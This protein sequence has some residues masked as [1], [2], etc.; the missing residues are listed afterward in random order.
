MCGI[1]GQLNFRGN[2]K[3]ESVNCMINAVR[4]RGPDDSGVMASGNH[5]VV[6]GHRRLSILDLSSAGHQPMRSKDGKTLLVFN[7]EIYNYKELKLR[8]FNEED[9]FISTGDSELLLRLWEKLGQ[10]CVPLLRGM[11]AFAIW[12]ERKEAL[13]LVRDPCGI[14]PLYYKRHEFL[15]SSGYLFCSELKGLKAFLGNLELEYEA[16]GLFLKW[17]SIPAPS[18]IYK[19]VTALEAGT[20]LRISR[21]REDV[22][23]YWS[24]GEILC[25]AA[26]DPFY[27]AN[28]EDAV[29]YVRDLL[30][31]SVGLHLVSDVPVGA[32]L[33]GGVDSSA[34]VSLMHALGQ[35]QIGTFCIGFESAHF[36]ESQYAQK[37][38][39]L[40]ETDHTCWVITQS[41]FLEVQERFFDSMEQP[42]I[43]GLNTFLV[44]DLAFRQGYKVVTSGIGGDEIFAG[45][46]RD[47]RKLP[48]I[49]KLVQAIGPLLRSAGGAALTAGSSMGLLSPQ[50]QRVQAFLAGA[51]TLARA[52]DMGRGLFTGPEITAI[53]A[54]KELGKIIAETNGDRFLPDLKEILN[55]RDAVSCFLLER[56][57]GPQLLRDSDAFSMSFSLEL[58]TPLVDSVL[59]EKLARLNDKNLFLNGGISKALL[60]DAVGNLPKEITHRAKKGFTPPFELWLRKEKHTL[61]TSFIN[62]D[63]FNRTKSEYHSGKSH[64]SRLWSLIVMDKMLERHF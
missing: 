55:T 62:E 43:D 31:E 28:R 58:R 17:G 54:D 41:D 63:F 25:K 3:P 5:Q 46:S 7:G 51:P 8:Y 57:L 26:N 22:T 12:D 15:G 29:S 45:Y 64:W 33:S 18:T 47:F 2:L 13:F 34:V 11:F 56:Y 50:W 24:Y 19:G 37:V 21:D 35:R 48:K 4:H 59:Y 40:Y 23:R 36:D 6:F 39:D 27:A 42:S 9:N 30:L 44:S 52:L 53:F 10:D 20:I 14:K 1:A 32:F 49:W 60:I 16:L 61:N 38:A